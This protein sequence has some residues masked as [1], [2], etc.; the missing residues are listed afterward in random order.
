MLFTQS[1]QMLCWRAVCVV[2][3]PVLQDGV[4]GSDVDSQLEAAD[5]QELA[6]T[7]CGRPHRRHVETLQGQPV[8]LLLCLLHSETHTSL[9]LWFLS[10]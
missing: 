3:V 6:E 9:M 2:S 8:H 7:N 4:H 10:F 5:S 1:V